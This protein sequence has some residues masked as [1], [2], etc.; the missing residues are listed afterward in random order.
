VKSIK[1][2]LLISAGLCVAMAQPIM[3][4]QT[5]V[6]GYF[7]STD[8]AP[9]KSGSGDCVRAAYK[10]TAEYLEACGYE[11]FVEKEAAV[12][13]G[14][15]GTAVTVRETTGV[16]K[17][18]EVVAV[19]E[20]M[21]EEVVIGNVEFPFDSAELT[22]EYRAALDEA[23]EALAPHRDFLRQGLA[24]LNVIGH[25]D[26]RGAAEY[27]QKLSE[28]RAQA[29]ADYLIMQ[30]P[31]R[32]AFTNAMGRGESDPIASNDTAEGR[33]RNRRVVLQVIG[34]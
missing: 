2:S 31:T 13:S 10:D 34:K 7:K 29:V 21:I 17:K 5:M 6:E 3:A 1:Q 28:M 20:T 18:G 33:Q 12:E 32:E 30:D 16:M 24:S 26:S 15:T 25:T 27:N 23:S 14:E 22:P 11:R 8:G 19:T 4:Q 9:V